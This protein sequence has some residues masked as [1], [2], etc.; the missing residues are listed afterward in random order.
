MCVFG[1]GHF[2]FYIEVEKMIHERISVVCKF[3]ANF[4]LL[5]TFTL[6]VIHHQAC[7]SH[8]HTK[9]CLK[10]LA[11]NNYRKFAYIDMHRNDQMNFIA[12]IRSHLLNCIRFISLRKSE[13][14]FTRTSPSNAKKNLY[15]NSTCPWQTV[16][17][18]S[19]CFSGDLFFLLDRAVHVPFFLL[20]AMFE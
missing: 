17:Q 10:T 13:R 4:T 18:I 12:H 11:L 20:A 16:V 3:P 14:S 5:C 9:K 8:T 7:P 1:C 19:I 2:R 15:E 6:S